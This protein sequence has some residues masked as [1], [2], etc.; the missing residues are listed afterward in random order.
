MLGPRD[1][2]C[3]PQQES[4][5]GGMA[6]SG[7]LQ[8]EDVLGAAHVTGELGCREEGHQEV[9]WE[10]QSQVPEASS[11]HRKLLRITAG[12]RAEPPVNLGRSHQRE[13]EST[14]TCASR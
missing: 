6:C 11:I 3:E 4:E 5:R 14:W 8:G 2:A 1:V 7:R 12:E 13:W 10:L 9:G